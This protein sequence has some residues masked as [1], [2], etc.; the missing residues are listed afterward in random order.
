MRV[1]GHGPAGARRTRHARTIIAVAVVVAVAVMWA[2]RVAS[3]WADR[4]AVALSYLAALASAVL[5][6]DWL[7]ARF[8]PAI[9]RF[10]TSVARTIARAVRD[11]PEVRRI[12]ARFPR[13]FAWCGR[14]L[15]ERKAS[16]LYLTATVLGA[17]YFL[18]GF[19][20]IATDVGLGR[21]I[22]RYDPQISALVRAFRGAAL[23]RVFY[24]ATLFAD[25][26][27]FVPLTLVVVILLV[28][29][30][31]RREA[32]L[33]V[34]TIASGYGLGFI[35]NAVMGRSRPPVE[36]ALIRQPTTFSFPSGHALA[37]MLFVV[38]VGLIVTREHHS[39]RTRVSVLSVGTLAV[40]AIGL[41]RVYLGVHWPSDVLASWLLGLGWC[42]L[43]WGGF[44]MLGRYGKPPRTWKPWFGPRPRLVIT[45]T[46]TKVA[47]LL[48]AVAAIF[49]PLV[50]QITAPPP[51]SEWVVHADA[52]GIPQPTAYE[53]A[54]LPVFSEKLDGTNQEPI[55]IIFIGTKAQLLAAF[56]GA[57]WQVADAPSLTTLTKVSVAALRS[58]PYPTAPVTPS[59][60]GGSVQDVAFE[61]AT[62]QASVRQRH[63]TRFWE[64]R[65]TYRGAPVWVATASF[66]TGLEMATIAPFPTHHIDPD[67]DAERDYIVSDL[68][69]AGVRHAG[70][71]RVTDPLSGTNV[72]G[73]PWFTK[74]MAALL[75][76]AR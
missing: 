51:T 29:W 18:W 23:T 7:I 48:V 54:L 2:M 30:A 72:Q 65:F 66:D 40:G 25:P 41:S 13:F 35:I 71:V 56:G 38:M 42:T 59:F 32:L 28:M 31:R 67:L 60:L 3:S 22:V 57:G 50:A 17:V 58:K 46:V 44:L 12:E 20:E 55:G 73:D 37:S 34:S 9:W 52:Q 68:V 74:G 19:V 6:V 14:R 33:F 45:S 1:E 21:A 76:P 64:T 47:A 10:V 11:D 62:K 5:F 53:V 36:F 24:T 70:D 39:S 4:N 75:M 69:G 63:H 15:S 27:A 43:A 49:D 8:G 61:K 16:G 26:Y